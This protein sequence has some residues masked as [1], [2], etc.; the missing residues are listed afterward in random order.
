MKINE[1][2]KLGFTMMLKG[3]LTTFF[4]T[5]LCLLLGEFVVSDIFSTVRIDYGNLSL[6]NI[7]DQVL[8]AVFNSFNNNLLNGLLSVSSDD[9][10]RTIGLIVFSLFFYIAVVEVTQV[11]RDMFLLN[12]RRDQLNS[13]LLFWAFNNKYYAKVLTVQSIR[14]CLTWF[15]LVLGI[16]PGI[17]LYLRFRWLNYVICEYPQQTSREWLMKAWQMSDQQ[18]INLLWLELSFFGWRIL[19]LFTFGLSRFIIE[20]YY[21]AT[22]T[23]VYCARINTFKKTMKN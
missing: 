6:T 15:G 23:E 21:Q 13:N 5:T 8:A 22:F 9:L 10:I 17:Y 1:F 20:P 2:K 3:G 14:W 16:I 11:G 19:N 18:T 7:I 4:L 12:V